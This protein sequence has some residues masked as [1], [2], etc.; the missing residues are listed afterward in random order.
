MNIFNFG[1]KH[2]DLLPTKVKFGFTLAEVLIT[3]GII[4]VVAAI[5]IPNLMTNNKAKKLRSQFLKSYTTVQ[6]VFKLMEADDVSTDPSSY[7][8]NNGDMFYR[9]FKTY[10]A[11]S[12]DCYGK[13]SIPCYDFNT[14]KYKNLN[15]TAAVWKYYFDDG[16]ILLQD[17]TLLLFEQPSGEGALH[18][19]IFV[20]ING[21][22][23]PPNRLGYDLFLFYFAEGELKTMG[24]KGT[25]MTDN[26]KYCSLSSTNGINGAT[27]AH[28]AKTEADYFN[29]VVKNVK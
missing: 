28:R 11:G 24:D 2:V 21:V 13:K 16:Q 29:W 19:W 1:A 6:Q 18:I 8:R 20:D 3:L 4:G 9:T 14:D 17:G 5:T 10:L 26:D 27:C 15:N 7:N 22:K 12:T 25:P 23:E